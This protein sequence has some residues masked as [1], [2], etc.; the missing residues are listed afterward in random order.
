MYICASD[1]FCHRSQWNNT[2]LNPRAPASSGVLV[3]VQDH[4]LFPLCFP[5]T[6]WAELQGLIY[7]PLRSFAEEEGIK[8]WFNSTKP[9]LMTQRPIFPLG[10]PRCRERRCWHLIRCHQHP[11]PC[12]RGI[13]GRQRYA[14]PDTS[15]CKE[16]F[17]LCIPARLQ[18]NLQEAGADGTQEKAHPGL[19]YF[20]F[21]FPLLPFFPPLY[22][23][24]LVTSTERSHQKS[25]SP[26]QPPAAAPLS[27]GVR[28][29]GQR[30][31]C[32]K[33][34][35]RNRTLWTPNCFLSFHRLPSN[36]L[37]PTPLRSSSRSS[38]FL[39]QS[40]G[41]DTLPF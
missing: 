40:T 23:P 15:G 19:R 22:F 24:T 34:L 6:C 25:D 28:Y 5:H 37:G 41:D 39:L 30:H 14:A 21:F 29:C 33:N 1:S 38:G 20:P 16:S 2:K 36:V 10:N 7:H 12:Q 31:Y 35:G 4:L 8:R 27:I 9:S 11:S 18:L 3:P 32:V 13:A 26:S 17:M